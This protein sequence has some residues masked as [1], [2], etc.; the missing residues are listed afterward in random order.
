MTP[1]KGNIVLVAVNLD[2]HAAHEAA[3]DFPLGEMG[4]GADE[5]F[6]TEEL[7]AGATERRRGAQHRVRLDPESNPAMVWRVVPR[8]AG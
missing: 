7:F 4:I 5:E 1:D 2:P 8:P 3:L 6:E